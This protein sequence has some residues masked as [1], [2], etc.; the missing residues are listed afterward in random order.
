MGAER[1][2]VCT[3]SSVSP[4]PSSDSQQHY[5]GFFLG[6]GEGGSLTVSDAFA[7]LVARLAPRRGLALAHGDAHADRP[8]PDADERARWDGN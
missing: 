7:Q 8:F 4:E 6:A 3:A 2:V 1:N 5:S